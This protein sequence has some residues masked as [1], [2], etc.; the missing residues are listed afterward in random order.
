MILFLIYFVCSLSLFR[1]VTLSEMTPLERNVTDYRDENCLKY[2]YDLDSLP[3]VTVVIPFYNDALSMIL[4]TVH[5]VLLKT[6]EKLLREVRAFWQ[7][8]STFRMCIT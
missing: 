8:H 3:T 5:S 1:N 6:P 2:R 4:R 7:P